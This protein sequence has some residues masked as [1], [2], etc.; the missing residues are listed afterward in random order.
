MSFLTDLFKT[1]DNGPSPRDRELFLGHILTWGSIIIT[2]IVVIVFAGINAAE[3]GDTAKALA[4]TI[5][6]GDAA[7]S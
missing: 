1:D 7:I 2:F 4:P 5:Q 3:E 6:T